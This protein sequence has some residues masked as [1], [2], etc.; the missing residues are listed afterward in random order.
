M[1]T[2][3]SFHTLAYRRFFMYIC[4]EFLSNKIMA[5]TA[6]LKRI[7]RDIESLDRADK[8]DILSRMITMLK[9]TDTE[10]SYSIAD[11]KGLGKEVWK[12]HDVDAYICKERKSWD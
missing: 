1:K 8:L 10:K 3:F 5:T 6:R 11:L 9:K 2:I 7:V 12:Q 4:F